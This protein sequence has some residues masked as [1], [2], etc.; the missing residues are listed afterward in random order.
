MNINVKKTRP[1]A[2]M[3]TYAT[4]GSACFDLYAAHGQAINGVHHAIIDTGLAFELPEDHCMLVYSRSG[5]ALKHGIRLANCV[6]VIDS[7]YRDSVKV[8]LQN[9]RHP[10]FY[11][12]AG[13][14][15]AQAMIVPVSK[16]RLIE[17]EEINTTD[18]AG[19]FGSTGQ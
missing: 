11:I 16:V 12:Q 3:P 8:V 2:I 18:R 14:R 10:S 7:D 17:V 5:H 6:G 15:I 13:D 9:D 19:G 1:T 4:P